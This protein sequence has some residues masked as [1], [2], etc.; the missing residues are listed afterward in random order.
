MNT[1]RV[2]TDIKPYTVKEL[3]A[4]N[5]VCDKTFKKWL[6]PFA[7]EIG[8]KRGWYYNVNQV[9]IIFEKLGLPYKIIQ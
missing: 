8:E 3:A 1:E 5:N 2:V 6:Q 7:D 9:R 4:I